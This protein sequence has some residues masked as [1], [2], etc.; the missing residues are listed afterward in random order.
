MTHKSI[1]TGLAIGG[2]TLL[3]ACTNAP[4]LETVGVRKDQDSCIT[5]AGRDDR[6]KADRA[7]LQLIA[8]G[9]ANYRRAQYGL[10]EQNF[11]KAVESTSFGKQQGSRVADLEAWFGLAASYDRLGRFDLSDQIYE[12]V[13]SQYGKSMAYH[14]NYGYSLALRGEKAKA[15]KEYQA[16][17]KLAPGCQVP[18]NN[19][20]ALS[21]A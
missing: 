8:D 16:A 20:A 3:I 11:R 1:R 9:K 7:Q 18:H 21:G 10:A 15:R 17:L 19:L 13:R 14:N 12:H 2:C 6:R 5:L 4:S